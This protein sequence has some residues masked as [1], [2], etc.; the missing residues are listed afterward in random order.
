MEV[1]PER[2][3]K[4]DRNRYYFIEETMLGKEGCIPIAIDIA[5]NSRENAS[6]TAND[7][8]PIP[9]DILADAQ[10][11]ADSLVTGRPLDAETRR[12]IHERAKQITEELRQK[13]G[14]LDIGV[15]A[16]RELRGELP[17]T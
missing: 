6:M 8:P 3:W 17:E 1:L 15:P 9:A 12:R 2:G 11:V 14:E 10:A 13:Y 16:I 4:W 7:S 5:V